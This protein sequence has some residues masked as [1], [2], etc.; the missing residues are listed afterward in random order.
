MYTAE[1]NLLNDFDINGARQWCMPVI[2]A[3]QDTKSERSHFEASLGNLA[4][5]GLN[6]FNKN[7]YNMF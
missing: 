7:F 6:F 5:P 1:K 2:P 3:S 4:G